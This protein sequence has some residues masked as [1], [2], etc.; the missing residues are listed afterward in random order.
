MQLKRFILSAL[1]ALMIVPNAFG[2]G[3]KGHDVVAYVA[4][5][6]LSRRVLR[7]VTNLHLALCQC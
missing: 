1:M 6:N 3:Q 4:E 7:K 5:Q 2:W